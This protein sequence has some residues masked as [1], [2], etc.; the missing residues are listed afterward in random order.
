MAEE[1]E[2]AGEAEAVEVAVADVAVTDE[3]A[4]ATVEA[5]VELERPAPTPLLSPTPDGRLTKT[6]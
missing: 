4:E 5:T 3:V 1:A 6:R 2:E